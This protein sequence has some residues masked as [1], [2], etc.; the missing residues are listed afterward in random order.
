MRA[1]TAT[2]TKPADNSQAI[3]EEELLRREL[4]RRKVVRFADYVDPASKG[5]YLTPHLQLIGEHLDRAISGELW[6]ES[7]GHGVPIL[8]IS[9][10]PR[11]WKSSLI[12]QKAVAY[13]VGKQ[14]TAGLPH[15][16]ILTSYAASLAEKNSRGALE[17]VRDQPLYKNV[18]PAVQISR[19]R[20]SQTEWALEGATFPACVAAGVGGGLTGQG[21]DMLVIDD[22]IKDSQQANSQSYRDNLWEWW[23]EVARTRINPGGFAVIV[24]TRWHI[25]D[26]VGRLMKQAQEGSAERIVH[27]RLP[28]LAETD[29][30][31]Q[32]AARMGLPLDKADPLGRKPGRALWPAMYSAAALRGTQ[33]RFPRTFD[34]LYQGRPTPKGGFLLGREHFKMLA[35]MPTKNVR[36]VWGTDWAITAKEV[37]KRD[38]D[39]TVI[40]LVGLWREE[41]ETRIVIGF[42]ERGQ[43]DQHAARQMVKRQIL[44]AP[45]KRPTYAGQA[46]IDAIHFNEMSNDPDLIG[47][48]F[49]IL[50]HKQLSRTADKVAKAQ[51]WIERAQAGR[52]YVVQGAWNEAF[53]NEVEAFPNGMNDDMIDGVTVGTA[54]LGVNEQGAVEYLEPIWR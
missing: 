5:H 22:P 28:A 18:F 35:E 52:V 53:F 32:A 2:A 48:S 45:E 3:I 49:Q 11:H 10:P 47:Y 43:L 46:N 30:E 9:T 20:Q 37:G 8:A 50:T 51:P 34:A 13:F 12:S 36:W 40:A 39:Y 38:P 33:S 7:S 17:L 44:A 1:L 4:A 15:A 41:G 26:L 42:I 27:L 24:M 6:S 19:Q 25:D 54:A 14:A 21:A 31:R 16:T 23:A 29:E